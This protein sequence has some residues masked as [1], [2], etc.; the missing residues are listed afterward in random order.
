MYI[1]HPVYLGTVVPCKR[2]LYTPDCI[3]TFPYKGGYGPDKL[4][5][6]P[7]KWRIKHP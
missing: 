2:R 1:V 4:E 6:S 3:K 7:C 5:T